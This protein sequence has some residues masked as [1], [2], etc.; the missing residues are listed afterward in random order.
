MNW[1]STAI[2]LIIFVSGLAVGGSGAALLFDRFIHRPPVP[3]PPSPE[4]AANR[5]ARHLELNTEQ[6]VRVGEVFRKHAPQV[7]AVH[8]KVKDEMDAIL[9]ATVKDIRPILNEKQAAKL[10]LF[11]QQM[12]SMGPPFPGP[13]DP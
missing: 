12:K 1:K 9:D 13:G 5:L 4:R 6:E 7:R 3:G 8:A 10:D 2:V 11:V